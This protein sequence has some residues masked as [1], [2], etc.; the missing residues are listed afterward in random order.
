M[1]VQFDPVGEVQSR[2]VVGTLLAH[3]DELR[4]LGVVHLALF[5]SV[6]RRSAGPD[7]D[8]DVL[9]DVSP[10]RPFSLFALGE[11]RSR[12]VELLGRDVD[13]VIRDDL[14]PE[15]RDDIAADLIPVF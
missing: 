11:V 3:G 9:I 12:L 15:L 2:V 1:K 6:A 4:S 10:E 8:V 13:L 5:G 7:S 14:R